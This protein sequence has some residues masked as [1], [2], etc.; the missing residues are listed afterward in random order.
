MTDSTLVVTDPPHADVHTRLVAETL[1]LAPADVESKTRF[2]AP[3]VL[4]SGSETECEAAAKALRKAGLRVRVVDGRR[5]AGIPWPSVAL[6]FAMGSEGLVADTPEGVMSVPWG[7]DVLG[8][9]CRPPAG[10]VPPEEVGTSGA[11]PIGPAVADAA[12]WGAVLDLYVQKDVGVRRLLVTESMTDFS[13]LGPA[14][15]VPSRDAV[16]EAGQAMLN[17]FDGLRLDTRFDDVRPRQRFRMGDESFDID[18]RKA[19]SY[20]TLL[21]RQLLGSISPD[22]GE[23][24]Q[25]EFA[26]RLVH[27]LRSED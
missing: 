12:Q 27:L 22:L 14:A 18:M 1:R 9:L 5:L 11:P 2:G 15:S 10:F 3:E 25:W 13:G 16:S 24:T 20:G 21:L 8:I 19:Y 7:A 26:S 6:S 17:R 4:M 23:L